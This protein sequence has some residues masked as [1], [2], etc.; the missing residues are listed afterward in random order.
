MELNLSLD[1][2]PVP[3]GRPRFARMG[4]FVKTYDPNK[5]IKDVFKA[6]F[7][8]QFREELIEGP[9]EMDITFFMPIP[10]STSKVKRALMLTND[11]KHIKRPD[12]DNLEK[13]YQD[14]LNGIVY[15]DDS[16]IWQLTGRKL[17]SDNPRV[18]IKL[19]Y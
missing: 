13:I 10:K 2:V 1:G 6:K 3:Q 5:K 14:V 19:N 9:I 11:I 8:E 4:G 12:S 16:Q 15:K 17:Y 18:E 7:K